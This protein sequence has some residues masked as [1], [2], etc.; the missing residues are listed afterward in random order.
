MTPMRAGLAFLAALTLVTACGGSNVGAG[1]ATSAGLLKAGALVYLQTVSNP[2]S[3]QWEQAEDLLAKFPD[4]ERWLAQLKQ[5]LQDEGVTWEQDVKPA[6]GPVVDV[7]IYAAGTGSPAV[8]GL[9]NPEDKDKLLALVH[10][11]NAKSDEPAVSRVVGDWVAISDREESLEA[12]LKE[13]GGQTLA[14]D[15]TFKSALEEL[16]DD[17]LSRVYVDPARA[18]ELVGQGK[19]RD[20]LS[21]L[22]LDALDFA[23]AWAKPKGDGAELAITARGEG[24]GR[25]L[26]TGDP[27]AS[28]LLDQVP[29]DAFAFLSF[30]G[31]GLRGQ[32]EAIQGNPL[33]A[34]GL[35]DFER[36]YGIELDE[37]LSLLDGEVA[38]YVRPGLPLPE[39]TLLLASEDEAGTRDSAEQILRT[40]ATK[41]GGEVTEQG[42]V[43]EARFEGVTVALGTTDDAVVLST[44]TTVFARSVA[45]SLADSDR[46]QDALEAAKVPEQ[47]TGLAYVDL[48]KVAALT[49]AY[50][51]SPEVRRNLEPLRSLVVFGSKEG[52]LVSAR[53]FLEID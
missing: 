31:G 26:G 34:M 12:A 4:G 48:T 10:K 2:E 18:I 49:A 16:P 47:Y 21:L 40:A 29:D 5:Q 53:A 28:E 14:A 1:P 43:T 7:A 3:A 11:L 39:L 17:A 15:D 32:L 20:A 37:V 22:G 35:R 6:L 30:Q 24:A 19:E 23:G 38:F 50:S 27:Y 45:D 13:E 46:Y 25:L 42:A 33:F 8:V 9:T 52:D 51:D 41:L 36:E 44:S